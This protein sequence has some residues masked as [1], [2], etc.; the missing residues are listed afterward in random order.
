M[1]LMYTGVLR[2]EGGPWLQEYQSM[3]TF[4][5]IIL[6]GLLEGHSRPLSLC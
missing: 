3:H 6:Q 5:T 2:L 1:S 4:N